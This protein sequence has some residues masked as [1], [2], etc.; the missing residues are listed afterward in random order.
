MGWGSYF[1]LILTAVVTAAGLFS[2]FSITAQMTA[3]LQKIPLPY[4]V[5]RGTKVPCVTGYDFGVEIAY[6]Y[7]AAGKTFTGRLCREFFGKTWQFKPA[8]DDPRATILTFR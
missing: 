4:V 2:A 1:F 8:R 5:D 3:E 7:E 6:R